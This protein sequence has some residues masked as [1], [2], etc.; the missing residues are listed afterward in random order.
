MPYS[1]SNKKIQDSAF[2][3]RSGNSPLFKHMGSS[4]IKHPHRT[5]DEALS[6]DVDQPHPESE[7]TPETVVDEMGNPVEQTKYKTRR[8]PK[9]ELVTKNGEEEKPGGPEAGPIGSEPEPSKEDVVKEGRDAMREK[10]WWQF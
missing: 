8:D 6:H 5:W 3:M 1:K 4:P 7:I 10:R 2:S 9:T